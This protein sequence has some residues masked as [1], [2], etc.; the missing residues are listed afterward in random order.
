MEL[1]QNERS[2]SAAVGDDR[3]RRNLAVGGGRDEGPESTLSGRSAF[4]PS[5]SL[6]LVASAAA[7]NGLLSRSM[8]GSSR[9][10]LSAGLQA[11]LATPLH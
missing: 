1:S 5:N 8:P 3:Y 11:H 9:S 2:L 7:V 10:L 6:I 4:A